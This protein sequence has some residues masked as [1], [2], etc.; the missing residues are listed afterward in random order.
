MKVMFDTN[1]FNHLLDGQIQPSDIPKGWEPIATHIQ[2]DELNATKNEG[3][4]AD[5]L[6]T[7]NDQ[8]TI[9][10]KTSSAIWGVSTWDESSWTGPESR[11]DEIVASLDS[12][13]SK[14]NNSSD[15][16]IGDTCLQNGFVLVTNDRAL[17]EIVDRL[18]GKSVDLRW[19]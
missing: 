2:W 4:R 5:L 13:R 17:R 6:E 7:F 19:P 1:V 12:I 14:P 18:G 16:L 8:V 11:Y 15:A 10:V 9:K 3:R